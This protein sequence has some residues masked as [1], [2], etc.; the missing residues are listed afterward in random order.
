MTKERL[1]EIKRIMAEW[2][3]ALENAGE[4]YLGPNE[5]TIAIREMLAELDRLLDG[6]GG[7]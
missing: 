5:K 2:F 6:G 4:Y 1:A 7:D 3:P